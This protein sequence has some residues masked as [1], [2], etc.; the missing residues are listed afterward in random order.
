M[1]AG[2]RSRYTPGAFHT[3]GGFAD[4]KCADNPGEPMQERTNDNNFIIQVLLAILATVLAIVCFFQVY[5]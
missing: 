4:G 5:G 1:V 2:R 3:C